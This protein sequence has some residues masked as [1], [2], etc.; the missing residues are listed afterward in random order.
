MPLPKDPIKL[1]EY[2]EKQRKN[3]LE[4]GFGKWMLGK[5][6]SEESKE[7]SRK[8]HLALITPEERKRRSE[9]AK[10][11]GYG[12]WMKGRPPNSGFI[13]ASKARKGKT[14]IEI[15]GE[16]RAQKE[17]EKR[18]SKGVKHTYSS[19]EAGERAKSARQRT[20]KTYTEIY[21]EERA[22]E[23]AEKRS[24]AHQERWKDRPRKGN[25]RPYLSGEVKYRKWRTAVFQRDNWTCQT[26]GSNGFVEGHHIKSWA[27]F[28]KLRYEINNGVTLCKKCHKEV[29]NE[30]REKEKYRLKRTT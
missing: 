6:F 17:V 11:N 4:R 3:A 14:Y 21:G 30:Q 22:K 10:I 25:T 13:E 27:N 12:K 20:G 19:I 1:A 23:E 18:N 9:R 29:N 8:S 24:L 2:K 5:H 28:P 16:D 15:Y 7:K 26:C